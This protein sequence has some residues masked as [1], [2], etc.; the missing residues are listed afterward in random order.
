MIFL[1]VM[2]KLLL[3]GLGRSNGVNALLEPNF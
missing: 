1:V 3:N 2:N